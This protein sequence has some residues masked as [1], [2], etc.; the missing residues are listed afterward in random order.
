MFL[1]TAEKKREATRPKEVVPAAPVEPQIQTLPEPELPSSE[2][3]VDV[4]INGNGPSEEIA[5]H[6][7]EDVVDDTP[8]APKQ[9]GFHI[10]YR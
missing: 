7:P 6:K 1:R 4:H 5:A 8:E 9:V 2:A 10:L 3:V